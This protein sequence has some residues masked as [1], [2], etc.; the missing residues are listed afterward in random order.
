[1]Q[2]YGHV[3]TVGQPF[4]LPTCLMFGNLATGGVVEPLWCDAS[5]VVMPLTNHSTVLP[6][7]GI[8]YSI[9]NTSAVVWSCGY[10][11]IAIQVAQRFDVW[12]FGNRGCCGTIMV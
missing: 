8:L 12:P 7:E 4:K 3:F 11:G 5:G 2:L 9:R 10:C 6:F 1:M